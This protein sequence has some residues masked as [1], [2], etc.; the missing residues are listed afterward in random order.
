[1]LPINFRLLSTLLTGAIDERIIAACVNFSIET[2]VSPSI[3]K[4]LSKIPAFPR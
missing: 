4:T 2:P 1:M 3:S